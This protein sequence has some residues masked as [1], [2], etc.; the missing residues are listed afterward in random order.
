MSQPTHP[1]SPTELAEQRRVVAHSFG[2]D[3]A[4]LAIRLLDFFS[5]GGPVP[6]NV[7]SAHGYC[8]PGTDPEP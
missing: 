5:G 8:D 3:R 7:A 4:L 2:R 6:R 1:Y